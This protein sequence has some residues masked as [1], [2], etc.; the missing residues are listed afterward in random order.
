MRPRLRKGETEAKA[1]SQVQAE[2]KAQALREGLVLV[3]SSVSS[4]GYT[5]VLYDGRKGNP[6]YAA[7]KPGRRCKGALLGFLGRL[8][9]RERP[10]R[11][12]L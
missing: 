1:E 8:D 6:R 5:A 11:P 4:T 12:P 9:Q 10:A 2:A 7:Y 3:T